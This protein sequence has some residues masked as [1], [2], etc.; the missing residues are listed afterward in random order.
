MPTGKRVDPYKN[1]RFLVEIDGII[2]AGFREVTIPDSTQEPIEYREG[3]MPPTVMKQ[4][5]LVKYGNV[6]LKWGITDSLELYNWRKMVEDGKTKEARK[7]MAIILLDEEG[8]SA[9][10]WEFSEAWPS[11]YDAPDLNATG[12]EIAIENIEIVHEGM[13]RTQ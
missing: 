3:N 6:S 13:K 5:G 9:A 1:F 7:N 11:K 10:R 12:N 8:S 2:Q 4:P